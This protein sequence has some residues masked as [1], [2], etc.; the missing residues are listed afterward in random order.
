MLKNPPG[1]AGDARD[2]GSIPGW[3]RSPG[4]EN[5]NPLQCSYLG[6]TVEPGGLQSVGYKE[7]HTTEGLS[8]NGWNNLS[9]INDRHIFHADFISHIGTIVLSIQLRSYFPL[10]FLP[11]NP[12]H[13]VC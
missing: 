3:G 9:E 10:N 1:N 13:A 11:V 4:G 2:A 7:S 6:R 12:F 8:T 5:G